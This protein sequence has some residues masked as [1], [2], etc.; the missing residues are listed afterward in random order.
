MLEITE[1]IVDEDLE[2]VIESPA[3]TPT[4]TTID[5][6]DELVKFRESAQYVDQIIISNIR[7][8]RADI[9]ELRDLDLSDS[10]GDFVDKTRV[11]I[12]KLKESIHK[13]YQQF[14]SIEQRLDTRLLEESD[15]GR[16]LR[17]ETNKLTER[18]VAEMKA[19]DENIKRFETKLEQYDE[20]IR[21]VSEHRQTA[22]SRHEKLLG[23]TIPQIHKKIA[24]THD[25]WLDETALIVDELELKISTVAETI[26]NKTTEL[27]DNYRRDVKR[28]D[29]SIELKVSKTELVEF[30]RFLDL[31]VGEILSETI[32][33]KEQI[34][35]LESNFESLSN[36]LLEKIE[37]ADCNTKIKTRQINE[38]LK[39]ILE[40]NVEM[41]R[42]R[43][44]V[45]ENKL[46]ELSETV[47]KIGN[48]ARAEKKVL[49]ETVGSKISDQYIFKLKQLRDSFQAKVDKFETMFAAIKK[50]LKEK[51]P[52]V[53][54]K[55]DRE[56]LKDV[57]NEYFV[58]HEGDFTATPEHKLEGGFL[59]FRQPNGRWGHGIRVD[60]SHMAGGGVSYVSDGL[61]QLTIYADGTEIHD[62]V[63]K[64]NFTGSVD[65]TYD[66]ATGMVTV[67]VIGG[68]GSLAVYDEGVLIENRATKLNFIGADVKTFKNNATGRVDVFIPTPTY[69]DNFGTGTATVASIVGSVRNVSSPTG[70]F[71]I[72]GWTPGT[73]HPCINTASLVYETPT[74]YSVESELSMVGCQVYDG[75]QSMIA[76][77]FVV[78][79]SNSD[80]MAANIRIINSEFAPEF[81]RY[82]I[83]TRFEISLGNL[84][85]NGGRFS[86]RL[87]NTN[88]SIEIFEF[89][90]S[91][92][93]Y[94]KE[95]S[96]GTISNIAT[97]PSVENIKYMSG[98]RYYT[99]GSQFNVSLTGINNIN[100]K[101]Y[102]TTQIELVGS[103]LGCPS[104]NLAG[105]NLT[106]WSNLWNNA[107]ASFTKSDWAINQPNM[108]VQ[109]N[110]VNSSARVIDWTSGA[111]INSS[112][113]TMLIDT[114]ADNSTR[115]YEDFRTE[116]QRLKSDLMTGWDS[117]ESLITSDGGTG[118]QVKNTRL[119]YPTENYQAYLPGTT[120]QPDYSAIT[121][122]KNFYRR[123]WSSGA[124]FSNGTLTFT[125]T[126]LSENNFWTLKKINVFWT[127]DKTNWFRMDTEFAGGVIPPNGGS[128]INRDT[129]NLNNTT[130]QIAFTMG[131]TK[132]STEIWFRFEMTDATVAIDSVSLN[133][134]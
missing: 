30:E 45:A 3:E 23:L 49:L 104:L 27:A 95:S 31:H 61:G 51:A 82:C 32:Q 103:E 28:L 34:V 1:I 127:I 57:V 15:H 101:S 33:N 87:F 126:N 83:K 81:N 26:V 50:Q 122:T 124:T 5:I 2:I 93:F 131:E 14:K 37:T 85:P 68:G 130:K 91:D 9:E 117:A 102:P 29:E 79:D 40:S 10:F 60:Y 123:M 96:P 46:D 63:N 129:V 125:G 88:E 113:M 65:T 94:D 7:E 8:I 69:S 106:G 52:A 48:D 77:H 78:T 62:K 64:I 128:R 119:Y 109:S 121:G 66:E 20:D 73:A 41:L 99:T 55:I 39:K 75:T 134:T 114:F 44:D 132:F 118:L 6:S 36:L 108:F 24:K 120:A 100:D 43:F 97:T 90:Q 70:N 98:V 53:D 71:S 35:V 89:V 86:V 112:N 67:D 13:N 107:G 4:E 21:I 22:D 16:N 56:V 105:G 111:W 115:I 72:G 19:A 17:D 80:T 59:F 38:S 11:N 116:N 18:V 76:Q 74:K 110:S 54:L 42:M 58:E 133:W 84:L 25:K 12:V 47:S 92:L